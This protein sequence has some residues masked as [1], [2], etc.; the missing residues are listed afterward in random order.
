MSKTSTIPL[1]RKRSRST[2]KRSKRTDEICDKIK[3]R[4]VERKMQLGDRLPQEADL[5]AEFGASRSTVREA[6]KGMEAQGLISIKTGPAGGAFISKMEETHAMELLSNLFF[7]KQPTINDIYQLRKKLEPELAASLIGKLDD[8]D[9]KRLEDTISLYIL[10]ASTKGEEY[11]QR[12]A[13]LDFH[14]TLS[15][16][17][18]NPLLGFVCNFLQNLL[19]NLSLCKQ[20]YEKPN[21]VLREHALHYQVRLL[22]AL[23]LQDK[24][25]VEEIMYNHMCAAQDYM[26]K[27]EAELKREFLK[28]D[29]A[30]GQGD[31]SNK[32]Q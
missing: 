2:R 10:P 15:D 11:Q 22:Q 7:F 23:K 19:K 9:F 29:P 5:I 30:S 6:L 21:P 3:A 18:P 32:I 28:L 4:I 17:C 12:L 16:L 26:I 8:N 27:C 24:E 20:I 14:I 13:E 25:S 31:A 1:D